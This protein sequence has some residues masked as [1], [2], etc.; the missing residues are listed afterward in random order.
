ML[1]G[2]TLER[3]GIQHIKGIL[4]YGPPGTG[5]TLIARKLA[6]L[7]GNV[8]VKIINGPEL[9]DKFVGE[10]ERKVRELFAPAEKNPDKLHVLIFDEI[11][12][13]CKKRDTSGNAGVGDN[14]VNQILTKLDGVDSPKNILVFGMTNRKDRLE[15]HLEIKLPDQTGRRDILEIHTRAIEAN[16]LLGPKRPKTLAGVISK[17]WSRRLFRLL[18]RMSLWTAR[19]TKRQF[20]SLWNT[21]RGHYHSPP[22]H[23]RC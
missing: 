11:D 1:S 17:L 13:L 21:S 22:R 3:L 23:N 9:L 10:S 20:L 8:E 6:S 12:S 14:I 15:V 19:W 18:L 5:K 4:L 2:E 7:L 16:K